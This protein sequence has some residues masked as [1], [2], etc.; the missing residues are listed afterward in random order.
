MPL[1]ADKTNKISN[2]KSLDNSTKE[3]V[4]LL[5][6]RSGSTE[7]HRTDLVSAAET[8]ME[9]NLDNQL[10]QERL[11]EIACKHLARDI[12]VRLVFRYEA[13]MKWGQMRVNVRHL[14]VKLVD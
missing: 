13:L 1:H 8:P 7:E 12:G 10:R 3:Y 14:S 4:L 11:R 2:G 6:V 5:S 9:G